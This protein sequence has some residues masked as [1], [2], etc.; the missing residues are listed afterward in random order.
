MFQPV[1][2][3]TGSKRSQA[4]KLVEFFPKFST[5]YEPFIGG[6]SVLYALK[7]EKAVCGDL[8][9]P[10]IDLW[11]LIQKN[12]ERLIKQYTKDWN[13]LQNE[14][15]HIYYDI[16][17]R[18]N[19][20]ENPEDLFFLSRTCV[21]GL[22]RFNKAGAFNNSLHHTRR[23]INP[24]RVKNIIFDW[25]KN[26]QNVKFVHGDYRETIKNA[27]SDDFIYLDPPYHNTNGRYFGNIDIKGLLETLKKLNENKTKFVLSYD[28]IRENKY[29]IKDL[30]KELYK[31]HLFL[32]SGNSP[33][34]KTMSKKTEKVL[35]SVYMNW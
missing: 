7:P 14:G 30:P 6:G 13:K 33:F 9:K 32:E 24:D 11:K 26:I 12:P 35:E 4:N 28:G 8:C 20:H 16:R 27:N 34:K 10:L 17:D 21:N 31:R 29:Y 1:I 22:I 25:S 23:G 15:Y 3:W 18:F 19:K 5:Y 2:K